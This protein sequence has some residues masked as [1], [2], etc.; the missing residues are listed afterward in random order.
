MNK[1]I[2][3]AIQIAVKIIENKINPNIGCDEISEI[4]RENDS[5][6]E[7][8]IFELLS[9][10]Q[11]GHENIG[12]TAENTQPQIVKECEILVKKYS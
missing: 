4:S 3:K 2:D 7:L 12:I 9:H 6:D 1:E 10:E 5:P 11:Y 8:Q